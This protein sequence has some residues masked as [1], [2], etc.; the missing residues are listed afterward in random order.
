MFAVHCHVHESRVLLDWSRVEAVH[1]SDE[2]P[3]VD[4]HCW[5]GGRGRLVA[6]TRSERRAVEPVVLHLGSADDREPIAG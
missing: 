2:G 5:C 6:G 1:D 3:V 4:W